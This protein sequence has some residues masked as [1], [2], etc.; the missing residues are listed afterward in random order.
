M[1]LGGFRFSERSRRTLVRGAACGGPA[2]GEGLL[3]GAHARTSVADS[4][5]VP[6]GWAQEASVARWIRSRNINTE[7]RL[8]AAFTSVS[9]PCKGKSTQPVQVRPKEVSV[10][11]GSYPGDG[12]VTTPSKPRG[13]RPAFQGGSASVRAA[14]RVKPEQASKGVTRHGRPV[15]TARIIC[16]LV[17][18][19][20]FAYLKDVLLRVATHPQ[21]LIHQLTP[22]CW[23]STFGPRATA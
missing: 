7:K 18:V 6:L 21:R 20:P 13:Q 3:G 16:K 17:D 11:L 22:N 10:H 12:R 2:V 9:V 19:P 23:A 8:I 15:W 14:T 4:G 5:R 1:K